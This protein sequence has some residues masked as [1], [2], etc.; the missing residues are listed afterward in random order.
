MK[1]LKA[2]RKLAPFKEQLNILKRKTLTDEEFNETYR[3]FFDALGDN[4]KFIDISKP[5][6]RPRLKKILAQLGT[7]VT[8]GGGHV[9]KLM[10][11]KVP[12]YPLV[13]GTFFLDQCVSSLFFFED[14]NT[15]MAAI[16]L[17]SMNTHFTRISYV[18]E[19]EASSSTIH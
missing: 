10:L 9:T 8:K 5:V 15:G 19:M 1:P 14:I 2:N 3:Y 6:K 12:Y 11:L 18:T 7:E 13:H 17:P 4:Q 16:M